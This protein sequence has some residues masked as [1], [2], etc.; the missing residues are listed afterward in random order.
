MIHYLFLAVIPPDH[1][2]SLLA[3]DVQSVLELVPALLFTPHVEETLS[4][5]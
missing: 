4:V 2:H 1:S 5:C 3:D